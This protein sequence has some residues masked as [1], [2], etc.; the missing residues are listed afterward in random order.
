[1]NSSIEQYQAAL[2]DLDGVVFNTEP[3]YTIFWGQIGKELKPEL[4]D[5]AHQIKGQ[6]L[7]QIYDRYFPGDEKLQQ[8]ITARLNDYERQMDYPYIPGLQ[9]F[10]ERL[11]Q[12]GIP[13]AIVTSSNEAKMEN[14]YRHHPEVHQLFN[15][16]LTAE[17]F[18]RSKPDPDCYIRAAHSFGLQPCD[19]IGF[20]DSINGLKSL[21]AS[22]AYTVALATTNSRDI[23]APLA[24]IVIDDYEHFREL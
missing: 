8:Q 6:T 22:G 18:Q 14:V 5:F 24:D 23:L 13:T 7:T 15:H 3:Q 17:D 2:F 4:P 9:Q 21:R 19:C 20:E 11:H 10:V 12:Q 1:M 16:I